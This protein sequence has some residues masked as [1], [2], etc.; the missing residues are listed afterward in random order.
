MSSRIKCAG[1]GAETYTDGNEIIYC[2]LC[3]D[4]KVISRVLLAKE[5]EKLIALLQMRDGGSHDVDC[6]ANYGRQC[7]CGHDAV[8]LYFASKQHTVKQNKKGSV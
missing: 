2:K 3:F 1:C 5:N 6:K 8:K 7:N 4:T